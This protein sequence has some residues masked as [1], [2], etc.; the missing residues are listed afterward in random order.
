MEIPQNG[1][2]ASLCQQ[3]VGNV[4]FSTNV[5][6]G[7]EAERNGEE[8]IIALISTFPTEMPNFYIALRRFS[9]GSL[10]F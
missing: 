9:D 6:W 8:L 7:M 3:L 1:I 4:P 2:V 10:H 5:V